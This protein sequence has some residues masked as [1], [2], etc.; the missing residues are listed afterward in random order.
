VGISITAVSLDQTLS[1]QLHT[2]IQGAGVS[3]TQGL[4]AMLT[5]RDLGYS[6]I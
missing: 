6:K 2:T 3:L 1:E 5:S 4:N